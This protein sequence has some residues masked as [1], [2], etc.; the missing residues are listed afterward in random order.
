MKIKKLKP[1]KLK[2]RE[3]LKSVK[4]S[5]LG[6]GLKEKKIK[7]KDIDW[8][9]QESEDSYSNITSIGKSLLTPYNSFPLPS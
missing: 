8:T 5:S 7:A 3:K 2:K 4:A 1:R 9:G 6:T